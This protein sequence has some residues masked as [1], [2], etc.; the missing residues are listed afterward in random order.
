VGGSGV[1][2]KISG[3]RKNFSFFLM[4]EKNENECAAVLLEEDE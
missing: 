4:V 3:S 2:Q 1:K